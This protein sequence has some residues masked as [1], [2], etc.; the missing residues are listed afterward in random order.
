MNPNESQPQTPAELRSVR[1]FKALL[2]A[3][4]AFMCFCHPPLIFLAA[5]GYILRLYGYLNDPPEP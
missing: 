4:L 1:N 3:V 5:L 2:I